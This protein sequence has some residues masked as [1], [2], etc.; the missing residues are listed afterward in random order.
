[1]AVV[2]PIPSSYY[3]SGQGRL[4]IGDR[5]AVTGQFDNLI[6][7]GNVTSLTLDI[8]VQKFEHKE[9]MSGDRAIDLTIVQEKNATFKFTAE[10]LNFDML[11]LG[12]YGNHSAVVGGSVVGETHKVKL[13][14]AVP[15]KHPKVSAVVVKKSAVSVAAAGN[16]DYDEDFGTIYINPAAVGLLDNDNITVD[17][18]YA[19]YTK[20]EAFTVQTPPERYLRFEGLNTVDGSIRLVEIPRAAFEPLTGLEFINEELGSGEFN[21]NLLPDLTVVAQDVSRYFREKRAAG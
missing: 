3:Y 6:F 4:A 17:Y 9:S 5:D 19:A 21:G 2:R 14:Q 8:A 10:S 20:A 1:M 16:W 11:A 12:L 15:L 13:G 18:T 7:V